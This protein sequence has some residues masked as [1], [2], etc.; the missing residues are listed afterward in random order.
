MNLEPGNDMSG[1]KRKISRARR[2]VANSAT[3]VHRFARNLRPAV[4]DD[5]GLIPALNAYNKQISK[6]RKIKI[7]LKEFGQVEALE[8]A[9]QIV[10]YRVAQEALTN[11]VRHAKATEVRMS[12]RRVR[13][14]IQMEIKDDGKSFDV[15]KTLFARNNR[16]LGLVGM[17]ER[18][19]MVGGNLTIA[20]AP[21]KGTTLLTQ[22]PLDELAP[23]KSSEPDSGGREQSA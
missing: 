4:L 15:K 7:L 20:S 8:S 22:I 16:R 5:L 14:S 19:E 1:I 21:G 9:K 2:L 18:I 3:A 10:L 17:K 12:I 6:K 13:D 23:T 11:V